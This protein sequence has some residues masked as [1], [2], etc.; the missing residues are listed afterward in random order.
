MKIE[1]GVVFSIKGLRVRFML[2]FYDSH[3]SADRPKHK[4]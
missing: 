2:G 3:R 1:D 4:I